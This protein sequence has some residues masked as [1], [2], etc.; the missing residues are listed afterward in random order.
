MLDFDFDGMRESIFL[1]IHVKT[2]EYGR[3][4]REEG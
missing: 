4:D 2:W 3:E 1:C